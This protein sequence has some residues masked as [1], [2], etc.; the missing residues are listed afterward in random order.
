M[1]GPC[2]IGGIEPAAVGKGN[3]FSSG[4]CIFTDEPEFNI[5]TC[6]VKNLS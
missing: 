1:R 4:L 3:E 5:N 2:A 6:T